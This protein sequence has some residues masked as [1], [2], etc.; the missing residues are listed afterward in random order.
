MANRTKKGAWT[1]SQIQVLG[2]DWPARRGWIQ[3]IAGAEISEKNR[4][5]F[6]L[7]LPV[8]K[9]PVDLAKSSYSSVMARIRDLTDQQIS[10]LIR[11]LETEKWY[12]NGM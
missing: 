10:N 7:K 6:E 2:I 5:L 4:V 8:K 11:S 1:K 12:R 3:D 9:V